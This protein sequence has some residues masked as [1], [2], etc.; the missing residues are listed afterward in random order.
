MSSAKLGVKSG[1]YLTESFVFVHSSFCRCSPLL[2]VPTERIH[3][4][5]RALKRV[6]RFHSVSFAKGGAFC[7][8]FTVRYDVNFIL[9]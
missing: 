3:T 5:E 8:V 2:S 7:V 4:N 6:I 1:F 9:L